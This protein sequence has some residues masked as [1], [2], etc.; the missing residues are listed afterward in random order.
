MLSLFFTLNTN[1]PNKQKKKLFINMLIIYIIQLK[2]IL[3]RA[4]HSSLLQFRTLPN[5][6]IIK[7]NVIK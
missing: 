3:N 2:N 7:V 5:K 4:H 1:Q 6:K